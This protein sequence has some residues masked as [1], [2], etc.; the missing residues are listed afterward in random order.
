MANVYVDPDELFSKLD[1]ARKSGILSQK[2]SNSDVRYQAAVSHPGYI[3]QIRRDG[4][5][6]IGKFIE[7]SFHELS[8][9][10]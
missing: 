5:R 6:S 10:H 1:L 7:G 4:T 9:D 8:I 2:V 3:E